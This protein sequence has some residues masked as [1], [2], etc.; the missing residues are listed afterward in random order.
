[1]NIPCMHENSV[2][3]NFMSLKMM[4]KLSTQQSENGI[5]FLYFIIYT[6]KYKSWWE[7][8]K[9]IENLEEKV[10]LANVGEIVSSLDWFF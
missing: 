7:G 4:E 10:F 3:S 1:M 2:D 6:K 5:A 8:G 9:K